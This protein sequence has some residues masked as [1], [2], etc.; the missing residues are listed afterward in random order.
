MRF[1]REYAHFVPFITQILLRQMRFDSDLTQIYVQKNGEWS[2]WSKLYFSVPNSSDRL[3]FVKRRAKN[4]RFLDKNTGVRRA[5]RRANS[6][7]SDF[8]VFM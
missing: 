4:G 8:V 2:L 6:G 3:I 7:F 5:Q 1:C